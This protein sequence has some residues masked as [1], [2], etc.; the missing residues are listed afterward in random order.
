MIELKERR[1]TIQPLKSKLKISILDDEEINKINQAALDIIADVGIKMPSEK[2]LKIFA[3]AS[4]DVDF[5]K[6]IV[7]IPSDMVMSS[8]E[9]APPRYKLCGRR[10]ELDADIGGEKGTYFYCSGEA[11]KVVDLNTGERRLSVKSDYREY[12][13]GRRLSSD[14]VIDL[15]YSKRFR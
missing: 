8:L 15:A 12:G 10:P 9:Q 6:K 7:K 5:D 1:A 14:H 13:E 3:D 11:P 2:A 4:A